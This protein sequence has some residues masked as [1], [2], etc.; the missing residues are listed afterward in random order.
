MLNDFMEN[1]ENVS[2][3]SVLWNKKMENLD[4]FTRVEFGIKF[5]C[6][7]TLW[8]LFLWFDSFSKRIKCSDACG[9]GQKNAVYA[10]PCV[11]FYMMFYENS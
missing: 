1:S 8:I 5:G 2:R 9:Q 3:N 11:V 6:I 10:V 4:V 7:E